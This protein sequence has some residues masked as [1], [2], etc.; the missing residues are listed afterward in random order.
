MKRQTQRELIYTLL[1]EKPDEYL[2]VWWFI[3]EKY[4]KSLGKWVF[5]SHRGPARLTEL[6]QEGLI[7]RKRVKGKTGAY[8]YSYKYVNNQKGGL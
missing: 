1:S 5:L 3:G 4:S 7:D 8:Y 6:Y 2:P